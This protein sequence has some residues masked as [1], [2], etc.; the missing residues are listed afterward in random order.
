MSMEKRYFTPSFNL[1]A[2]RL[3]DRCSIVAV[4]DFVVDLRLPPSSHERCVMKESGM[5]PCQCSSL[6]QAWATTPSKIRVISPLRVTTK[7]FPPSP[8]SILAAL[9]AVPGAARSR[10]EGHLV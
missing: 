2:A 7:P 5:A 10:G 1:E 6:G 8:Y 4:G 3:L 9:V